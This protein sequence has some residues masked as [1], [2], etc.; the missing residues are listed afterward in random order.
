MKQYYYFES[1]DE[2]CDYVAKDRKKRLVEIA[3]RIIADP[4]N[5][6]LLVELCKFSPNQEELEAILPQAELKNELIVYRPLGA[7]EQKPEPVTVFGV[8]I[9]KYI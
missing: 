1:T 2:L 8:D 9:S 3:N 4:S 7:E 5:F 6:K